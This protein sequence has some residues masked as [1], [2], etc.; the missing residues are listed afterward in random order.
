[1]RYRGT[2]VFLA[3]FSAS[4]A[5]GWYAF[6]LALYERSTQPL[7]FSHKTHTGEKVGMKCEDC[8]GFREDGSFEGLPAVDKCA[9]CHAEPLTQD[10]S[11]KALVEQYIK[12]NRQVPW[13][14]YA[15]QPDNV[16]FSHAS[17]VRL[18]KLACERCHGGHGETA[19]LRAFERNRVSG[20]SR[21]IW[22]QSL[23]RVNNPRPGMKMDDCIDCHQQQRQKNGCLDCHK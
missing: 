19:T 5:A 18:A 3:G 6:P 4:L 23:I 1:M 2:L 7:S 14:V 22:G 15:R 11:E 12:P 21:D 20:Y 13:L 16:Y 17:H 8:H 9:A 10:P